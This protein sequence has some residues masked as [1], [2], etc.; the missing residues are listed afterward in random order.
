MN[1]I[2]LKFYN[3]NGS[4]STKIDRALHTRH[5]EFKGLFNKPD[6]I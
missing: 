5:Y 4:I 3:K 1:A 2:P 6:N